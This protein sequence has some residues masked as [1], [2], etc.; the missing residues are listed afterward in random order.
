MTLSKKQLKVLS[1]NELWNLFK[2]EKSTKARDEIVNRYLPLANKLASNLYYSYM[3]S[4]ELDD[5]C[6]YAY[7][8]LLDAINKY[9]LS[10]NKKFSTYAYVRISGAII[11]EARKTSVI[12]RGTRKKLKNFKMYLENSCTYQNNASSDESLAYAFG[13]TPAEFQQYKHTHTVSIHNLSSVSQTSQYYTTAYSEESEN[14]NS[15]L[16]DYSIDPAHIT[17]SNELH[18]KLDEA[19]S[20]LPNRNKDIMKDI[21]YTKL[22]VKVIAKKYD[23]TPCAIFQ[24]K[25]KSMDVVKREAA[26]MNLQTFLHEAV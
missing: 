3:Q 19:M 16:A 7:L 25:R 12:T 9:D 20:F 26:R 24:I 21:F 23:I 6:S 15:C 11:D 17:I 10:M 18:D 14:D 2:K 8:G 4:M 1:E 5:V 13:L 22:P